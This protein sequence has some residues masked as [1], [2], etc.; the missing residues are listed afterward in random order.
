MVGREMKQKTL[1]WKME[2]VETIARGAIIAYAMKGHPSDLAW[3][4][5]DKERSDYTI[6][7]FGSNR[8]YQASTKAL[9]RIK[10]ET[11]SLGD[12]INEGQVFL[13]FPL[14][15]GKRFCAAEQITRPDGRYCWVVGQEKQVALEGIK[16]ILSAGVIP[17]YTLQFITLPDHVIIQFAPGVGITK[18]T[19]VHHGTVSE[20]D[21]QL[22]EY[23]PAVVQQQIASTTINVCTRVR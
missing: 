23:H 10:D 6:I 7:Q 14:F 2:V 19:Y 22:I 8:F 12:L 3:Y 9:E 15:L 1:T 16:G 20:V 17:E 4:E 18:Y 11:D 13:D 5:E 21:V